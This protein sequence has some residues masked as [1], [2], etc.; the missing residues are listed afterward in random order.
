MTGLYKGILSV[1]RATPGR[2]K[3]SQRM[4]SRFALTPLVQV[5]SCLLIWWPLVWRR[6][7][8]REEVLQSLILNCSMVW[9]LYG[10]RYSPLPHI[11]ECLTFPFRNLQITMLCWLQDL[12]LSNIWKFVV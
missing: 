5:V 7:R 6:S 12:W 3:I 2:H 1:G 11:L 10:K 9:S 4:A 8:V